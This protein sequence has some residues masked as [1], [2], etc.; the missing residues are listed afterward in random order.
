[1]MRLRRVPVNP[2]KAFE[3]IGRGAIDVDGAL[4]LDAFHNALGDGFGVPNRS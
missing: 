1:M 3:V 4:L 2:G